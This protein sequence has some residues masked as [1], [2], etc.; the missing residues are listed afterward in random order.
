LSP[1]E[2]LRDEEKKRIRARQQSAKS[3]E[4]L[5]KSMK[6][7]WNR[8][9]QDFVKTL[10]CSVKNQME[11]IIQVREETPQPETSDFRYFYCLIAIVMIPKVQGKHYVFLKS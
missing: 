3:L 9:P 6:E 7:E 5:R 4:E 11:S 8:I 2:H 1:I 10:I